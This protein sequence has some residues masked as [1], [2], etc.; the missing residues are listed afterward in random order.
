MSIRRQ[1]AGMYR[2]YIRIREALEGWDLKDLL[3]LSDH[4]MEYMLRY[5]IEASGMASIKYEDAT[6]ATPEE[7]RRQKS[8]HYY[9]SK[10]YQTVPYTDTD[11]LDDLDPE[12]LL[13][14]KETLYG[15]VK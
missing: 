15:K 5:A 8:E 7:M 4:D 14:L 10:G 11:Q 13:L 12:K 6:L 2:K 9:R 1:M 3:A